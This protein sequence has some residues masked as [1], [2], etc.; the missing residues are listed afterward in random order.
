LKKRKEIGVTISNK[1]YHA[2][3]MLS[4]SRVKMVLENPYEFQGAYVTGENKKRYTDA[5]FIGTL[6]HTFV[7]EPEKFENDYIVL[8]FDGTPVKN[9]LVEAIERLGG[10]VERKEKASG[11]GVTVCDTIPILREKLNTLRDKEVRTIVTQKQVEEAKKTA[12]KALRSRY[13]IEANG[14]ELLNAELSEVLE[15][16]TCHVERT[17][18]GEILG[19]KIQVRP[20]LLVD[21]GAKESVWFCIDLKTSIDATI[22][23]FCRQSGQ[24]YYD[25]QEYIYKEVLRQNGIDVVD[26]RFCVAGKSDNSKCSYYK[27]DIEDIEDA[28]K[29]VSRT[30]E[31]YKFCR[32][33]DIWEE[34]KFDFEMMRFEPVSIVKLPSYRKFQLIDLGVL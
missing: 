7:L 33:N 17:F 13:V 14:K 11:G 4:A 27:M 34:G 25:V 19:V 21:L 5:L 23:M 15:L 26:F 9:D 30:L 31:K 12:E 22:G 8:G 2:S 18:H 10:S 6:H 20:D 3:S 1:K 24:Y 32:D 29:I 28:G 16:D